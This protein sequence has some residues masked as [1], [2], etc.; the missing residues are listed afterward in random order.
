MFGDVWEESL[1]RVHPMGSKGPTGKESQAEP[2]REIT[3][4]A[5]GPKPTTAWRDRGSPAFQT[6]GRREGPSH[7]P[8]LAL[9]FLGVGM[10]S[11]TGQSSCRLKWPPSSHR[12]PAGVERAVPLLLTLE[13]SVRCPDYP[14]RGSCPVT[15]PEESRNQTSCRHRTPRPQAPPPQHSPAAQTWASCLRLGGAA[16]EPARYSWR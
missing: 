1:G 6:L 16:P 10:A 15:G 8:A 13:G 5:P 12:S 11:V 14:A 3:R 7:V 9:S 2:E 4:A